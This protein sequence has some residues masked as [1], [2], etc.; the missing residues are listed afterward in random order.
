MEDAAHSYMSE[1]N[2]D[3]TIT[4]VVAEY[5]K[6]LF[7][8]IR[9]RVPTNED[10]E[11]ILQEVWY[12]FSRV[13]D[14]QPIEQVSGWLFRVAR[15]KVTDN[16]RKHRPELLEDQG[17]SNEDGEWTFPEFLLADNHT[18][19]SET[20]RQMFWEELMDAL[21]DLPA[22]Q[23]EVFVWNELEDQTF[24]EIADRTGDNIKTLIS[25]KRYAVQFLRQRLEQLYA[26]FL[27]F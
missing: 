15:N 16:Y 23:S 3:Q 1:A 24:R 20:L 18:P 7:S 13:I 14:V 10:A 22:S 12:Q 19:E 17:Y 4:R 27:E 9:G 8:F 21:E 6:R 11:D 25:R 2:K 5:G 26:E